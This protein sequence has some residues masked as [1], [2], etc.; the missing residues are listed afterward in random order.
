VTP[1]CRGGQP[2]V[3]RRAEPA[4]AGRILLGVPL[5]ALALVLGCP[6]GA[7]AQGSAGGGEGDLAALGLTPPTERHPAP[8]FR[9]EALAG[10][11]SALADQAGRWVLVNFWATWC[12]PCVHELP[13]LERLHRD[14]GPKGLAVLAVNVD[15]GR[16]RHV[17]DYAARLGLTLPVLLDPD[18]DARRDYEVRALPTTY[19]IGPDGRIAGRVLGDLPWDDADHRAAFDRLLGEGAPAPAPSQPQQGTTP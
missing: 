2:P 12:K 5:L 7:G 18:G 9:L 15:R 13:A 3:A 1:G 14:Y 8:D 16:R 17:A 11:E 6:P 19:L 4:G 10:G